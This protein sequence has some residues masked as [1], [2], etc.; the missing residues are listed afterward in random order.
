MCWQ[1]TTPG[2]DAVRRATARLGPAAAGGLLAL[3]AAARC[4]LSTPLLQ[5]RGKG[6]G[7]FTT[8]CLLY[9]GAAIVG[10]ILRRGSGREAALSRT[11]AP[12]LLLVAFFGAV[13]GPVAL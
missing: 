11:D 3:A 7:P 6:L 1:R 9:A 5:L 8:A 4:G 12:R 2:N 10:A 13:V